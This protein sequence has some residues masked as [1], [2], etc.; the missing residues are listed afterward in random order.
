MPDD[1]A[2]PPL[3]LTR[4]CLEARAAGPLRDRTLFTFV[5][6]DGRE[7]RWTAVEAWARIERTARGLLDL[8]LQPG[9]RVLVRLPHA[10]AYAFAFFAANLAGLVP[11]PSSPALTTEEAAFLAEDA[12]AAALIAG[13]GMAIDGFRGRILSERDLDALDGT[14]TLPVTH[15]EDPAFLIY[16]SGTTS[17]PKGVLHAQR[18][19][20]GRAMM[21]E[22]WQG[23]GPDDVTLHA[24][25]LNWSYTLGV[26]LMDAWAAGSHAILA[27]GVETT[28]WPALMARLGVTI[29]VAV[30]TVYRQMLK[31]ARPEDHDLSRLR[32]VLVSGEALAPTLY[33]EWTSRTGT[34]MY[35]ALGMTELSTYISAG[36]VTPVRRGSPGRPQPGRRVAILDPASAEPRLLPVGE[37]GLLASHRSDPGLMLRYW[38]R[39]DEEAVVFR[40]E[41]FTGGDLAALDA[42]GYV[43]FHGR[44]DD[45]IKSFG[46]RLSPNEIEAAIEA[47]PGVLEVAVVGHKIDEQKTLVTAC[48]VPQAG[49]T[50]DV[51]TLEAHAKQHLAEYKRP[52]EFVLR[53]EPLPRTRNGKLVRRVVLEELADR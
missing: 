18:T 11:I 5:H 33:D 45:T 41:W 14:A 2:N 6:G 20:R 7:E 19:V 25:T 4:W 26:G 48:V 9:E 35:E 3:N 8:G 1:A 34:E 49:V 39:P 36:P 30:P 42:D 53:T 21:R 44:A 50:L 23:F 29:F 28:Q 47:C 10:P 27:A 17:K 38:H 51:A 15:A 32:H 12:E 40:G 31:Y 24:G 52:H 22:G 37:V 43:W 13:D 16:T 46:Y